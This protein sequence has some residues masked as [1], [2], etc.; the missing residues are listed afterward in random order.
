MLPGAAAGVQCLGVEQRADL[1]QR[2]P[3]L[4]VA[5]PADQDFAGLGWSSPTVIRM[6]V[7]FPA[8]LGPRNPVTCPGATSQVSAS[9]TVFS[10]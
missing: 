2:V 5:L 1:A 3:Q 7:D 8:P 9:T 6:V 4:G 10:P